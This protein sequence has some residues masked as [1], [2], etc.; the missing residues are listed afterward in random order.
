M[1]GSADIQAQKT[2]GMT[3][4]ISLAPAKPADLEKSREL[5]GFLRA[6]DQFE[7]NAELHQR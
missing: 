7:D 6:Q 3:S 2:L 4:A 5:E 1:W